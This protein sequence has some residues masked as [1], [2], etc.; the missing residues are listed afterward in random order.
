MNGGAAFKGLSN[1]EV[2]EKI[3]VG[4]TFFLE[5]TKNAECKK[6][7]VHLLVISDEVEWVR[8]IEQ[9]SGAKAKKSCRLYKHTHTQAY[10]EKKICIK[11]KLMCEWEIK[12]KKPAQF[13][14]RCILDDPNNGAEA[15]KMKIL[16]ECHAK[17]YKI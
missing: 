15:K 2:A 17:K 13:F 9:K 16:D 3:S 5:H 7:V 12:W 1:E 4:W 6:S 8:K 10:I 14:S 11:I